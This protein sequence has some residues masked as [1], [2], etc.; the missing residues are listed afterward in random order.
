MLALKGKALEQ[1]RAHDAR[2]KAKAERAAARKVKAEERRRRQTLQGID[3]EHFWSFVDTTG[4]PH[5]CHLWQ[6]DTRQ[7]HPGRENDYD[8]GVYRSGKRHEP[9]HRLAVRLALNLEYIESTIDI[10]PTCDNHLCCNLDHLV[11]RPHATKNRVQQSVPVHQFFCEAAA[12]A[13]KHDE[14]ER[15]ADQL[16]GTAEAA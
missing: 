3:P 11:V 12:D 14:L 7:S 6:G 5:D 16:L 1:L 4:G 2:E 13:A 8:I 10:A 15:M 9:A